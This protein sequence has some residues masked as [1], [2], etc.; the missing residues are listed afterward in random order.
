MSKRI[1]DQGKISEILPVC[2]RGWS[3]AVPTLTYGLEL[4]SLTQSQLDDL[5]REGR[6]AIKQ[7]FSV[8]KHSRN[9]L[10]NLLSLTPISTTINNNKLNLLTRLMQ[11][12]TTKSVVL[13]IL[14][15]QDGV[16]QSSFVYDVFNVMNN[17]GSNF[18]ELLTSRNAMKLPVIHDDIQEDVRA[19]LHDC[20]QNWNIGA[21]RMEFKRI[22]EEHVPA[23]LD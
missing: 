22:M 12:P 11:H 13:S 20:L 15:L 14:S 21:R 23:R 9:Y 5:D 7:L 3:T 1:V 16:P 6:K 10:H 17:I 4:C 18:Y 2:L 19:S 8:S